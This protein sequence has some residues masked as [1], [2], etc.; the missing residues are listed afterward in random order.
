[1]LHHPGGPRLDF[2][3]V[4]VW[5][6]GCILFCAVDPRWGHH[7]CLQPLGTSQRPRRCPHRQTFRHG[8]GG[9]GGLRRPAWHCFLGPYLH[10]GHELRYEAL[11]RL[12]RHGSGNQS[13]ANYGNGD[14]MKCWNFN[15]DV[16]FASWREVRRYL[17][18][19]PHILAHNLENPD[20]QIKAKRSRRP[21]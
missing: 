11:P 6:G 3:G 8:L 12:I 7:V 14:I 16:Y 9:L 13:T 21:W 20:R 19:N 15:N 10:A 1:M 17:R 5:H 2:V 4:C 18:K